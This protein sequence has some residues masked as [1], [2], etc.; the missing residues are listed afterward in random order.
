M[1]AHS[2]LLNRNKNFPLWLERL[3][4]ASILIGFFVAGVMYTVRTPVFEASDE[5]WH[6]P[7]V[8]HLA[9]GNRL[10]VQ[11]YNPAEAGP[12]KQE[13]SQP[14]LYYY[15]AA[16]LTFWVDTSDID[17]ARKLNPHVDTGV[18]TTDGNINLVV[19]NPFQSSFNG[20]YLAV[21]LIRLFSVGL[22]LA[23]VLLTYLIGRKVAPHRPDIALMAAGLNAFIPMFVFI[24][25]SV[26]NDNLA[27]PLASLGMLLLI[28]LMQY[29]VDFFPA[30]RG[31][32]EPI[33]DL[34]D[35]TLLRKILVLGAVV[36]FAVLTKQG[37]IG[38]IPLAWGTFF[39]IGWQSTL[40]DYTQPQQNA[41]QLLN[42]IGAAVLRSLVWFAI[43]FV[44][45]LL[46]A[47]WWYIRNIYLY[48]DLLG[49]SAFE[50]V[51]G[52]RET[53]ASL[54]QLWDERWGFML[55]YWGLFGGLNVPMS[56]WIYQVMTAVLIIAIP[57]AAIYTVRE[58]RENLWWGFAWREENEIGDTVSALLNLVIS[59]FPF[60][61][62]ILFSFAI[63]YGLTQWA[64]KTW[65]SQGR[66]AFTAISAL[67][68]LMAVGLSTLFDFIIIRL[69]KPLT[70]LFFAGVTL[71]APSVFIAPKYVPPPIV[72][73]SLKN[74]WIDRFNSDNKDEW[75]T[76]ANN[77]RLTGAQ[78]NNLQDAYN[79][80]QTISLSTEWRMQGRPSTDWSI[81]VHLVDPVLGIPVAQRDMYMAQGLVASSYAFPNQNLP[82]RFDIQLPDTLITPAELEMRIGIYNFETAERGLLE[83]GED[84]VL[85]D[86]FQLE[87]IPGEAPNP[88]SINFEDT[89]ELVGFEVENRRIEPAETVELTAYWKLTKAVDIDYT[90]FSQIVGSD[91]TR[92][93]AVDLAQ[94][95]SS[96]EV[97]TIQ[98]VQMSLLLNVDAP[99]EVYP[100]RMGIY[101]RTEDGGFKNLQRV[102]EDD[103]LTDDFINLT[104]IRID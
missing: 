6:Y 27:I 24:S 41:S 19:R 95:T 2:T 9:D 100:L 86:V 23:T 7:M 90:F 25:G 104:L 37:T 69:L 18:I 61:I 89:F 32:N 20:T 92:W 83:N 98:P 57:G 77:M 82:S 99:A 56:D 43:F 58:V 67:S 36:G 44:P 72:D 70:I 81:F 30:L 48:G 17:V 88:V 26:N 84:S 50:A 11:T 68:I 38:L 49:W 45:I 55:S 94:P 47:G 10:P 22:G 14:P 87:S 4:L 39:L 46:I 16:L 65:S 54:A 91:T 103:R 59:K 60:V 21:R 63:V 40:A 15:V 102:T 74:P 35:K 3:L 31:E 42:Q 78:I 64:T 66:L 79:P 71:A 51:L 13:A 5:L 8:K 34:Y 75:I 101:S 52:V 33:H 97:G 12:W 62:S 29:G 96:W 76:F 1:S 80:G 53:P 73:Q 28:H 93:A 85:L